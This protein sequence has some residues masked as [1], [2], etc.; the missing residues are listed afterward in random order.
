MPTIH[1]PVLERALEALLRSDWDAVWRKAGLVLLQPDLMSSL[2]L[3]NNSMYLQRWQ[4]RMSRSEH[5]K[6]KRWR[7][8]SVAAA[9]YLFPMTSLSLCRASSADSWDE[10]CTKASPVFLP[11]RSVTMVIPSFTISKP[12][13]QSG[14]CEENPEGRTL[15][16]HQ[17]WGINL[18][19]TGWCRPRC[20]WRGGPW[21]APHRLQ[22]ETGR[23]SSGWLRLCCLSLHTLNTEQD[24]D[25]CLM[26]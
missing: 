9:P 13:K 7:Y 22:L 1:S 23:L 10:N 20:R 16:S 15:E 24:M 26:V 8:G 4:C 12:V 21:A 6:E 11:L 18:K 2:L 5:H 17:I 14:W 19:R 3:R 25:I